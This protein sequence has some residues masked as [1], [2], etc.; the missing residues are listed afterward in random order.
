M[1]IYRSID[2]V[3]YIKTTALTV[4]TF[5]G[6]H[7]GHRKIID[8]MLVE[9]ETDKYRDLVVTFNPHP[10]HILFEPNRAEVF[11]LTNIEERLKLLEKAG[12]NNVLVIPFD[13]NF[14][15]LTPA[16]FVKEV[17][18]KKVG[19]K[20]IYIG[21]DHFFGKGRSGGL[22]TLLDL[23]KDLDFDTKRV[24][25][26]LSD[27]TIVSS[28]KIRHAI[29]NDMIEVANSMLGYDYSISGSVIRGQ[30][31]ATG[32]GFPTANFGNINKHKLM[33]A[34]GVYLVRSK[35]F[36]ETYYGMANCGNR[37]TITNNIEPVLEANFFNFD[38]DIYDE[39]LEVSLLNFVRSER[40][41]DRVEQLIRQIHQD[42][43]TCYE[44]A[45]LDIKKHKHKH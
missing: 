39:P 20:K 9:S 34:N 26:R 13:S 2:E 1:N 19:L 22:D 5:D 12:V 6:V 14:S 37:P 16:E 21:Y 35:I 32:F 28:T 42:K 44:L 31:L 36:G 3:Q 45:S 33:P 27:S 8:E 40:K 43:M 18:V 11:L 10:R 30:G 29:T 4:G 24:E 41:F 25:V 7:I 23:G 38:K 15:N 17:L